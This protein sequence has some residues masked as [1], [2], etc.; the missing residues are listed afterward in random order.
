MLI[1][2]SCTS[3]PGGSTGALPLFWWQ[4]WSGRWYVMSIVALNTFSC[5]AAGCYVV[6]G[7]ERDGSR[8]AMMVGAADD[9]ESDLLER[10][11]DEMRQGVRRDAD[12]VH[13]H[14]IASEPWQR[15]RVR[16]D[17]ARAWNLPLARTEFDATR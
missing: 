8:T 1:G 3:S 10:R 15:E 17:I 7:R 2:G 13:V 12:E 5:A 6:A 4:G 16:C 11:W 9:I 14:L